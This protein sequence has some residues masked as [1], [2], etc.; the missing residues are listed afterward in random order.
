MDITEAATSPSSGRCRPARMQRASAIAGVIASRR[1]WDRDSSPRHT[2]AVVDLR[3]AAGVPRPGRRPPATPPCVSVPDGSRPSRPAATRASPL[4]A[5][6]APELRP[7][8]PARGDVARGGPRSGTGLRGV[9]RPSPGCSWPEGRAVPRT[10]S[11]ANSGSPPCRELSAARTAPDT[12][13][14]P[15]SSSRRSPQVVPVSAGLGVRDAP[16][17][18]APSTQPS[19]CASL[20]PSAC[21]DSR[22]TAQNTK[23]V[24]CFLPVRATQP[25]VATRDRR[26]FVH[27]HVAGSRPYTAPEA[28]CRPFAAVTRRPRCRSPSP[29]RSSS[30]AASTTSS[31]PLHAPGCVVVT[32]SVPPPRL[33]SSSL[34]SHQVAPRCRHSV[35]MAEGHRLSRVGPLISS[36]SVERAA[37]CATRLLRLLRLRVGSRAVRVFGIHV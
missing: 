23:R 27:Q 34:S 16:A 18:A 21:P 19:E 17:Q 1:R 12:E 30:R 25:G 14:I 36:S 35:A 31:R 24:S 8:E 28:Q 22:S 4:P 20:T 26:A 7:D 3:P 33:L 37:Q 10:R 6:R 29:C 32:H 15:A 9:H 2:L 5:L 11:S 13:R